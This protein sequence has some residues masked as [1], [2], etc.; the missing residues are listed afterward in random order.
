MICDET[1]V[2]GNI[3]PTC[4]RRGRD[5]QSAA[6]DLK[7]PGADVDAASDDA[8]TMTPIRKQRRADGAA[9]SPAAPLTQCK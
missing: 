4:S 7:E 2:R 9:P 1:C 8:M 3:M 5:V 6:A